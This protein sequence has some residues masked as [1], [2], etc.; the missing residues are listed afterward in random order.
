MLPDFLADAADAVRYF[1]EV[2]AAVG[3]V[4]PRA[5]TRPWVF[6][7]VRNGDAGAHPFAPV[8]SARAGMAAPAPVPWSAF[9]NGPYAPL[10]PELVHPFVAVDPGATLPPIAAPEMGWHSCNPG[11]SY[12]L[13]RCAV[14]A[15]RREHAAAVAAADATA[16]PQAKRNARAEMTSM[17]TYVTA[18]NGAIS[19][20]SAGWMPALRSLSGP[21]ALGAPPRSTVAV[22]RGD[23]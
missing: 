14:E 1:D 11:D 20:S 17:A 21:G 8:A 15:A 7:T 4:P 18:A 2:L 5:D 9:G 6:S 12:D 19:P 16:S 22:L 23:R 3:R 13:A 10:P